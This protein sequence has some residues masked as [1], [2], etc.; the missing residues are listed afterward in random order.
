MHGPTQFSSIGMF[1]GASKR[2]KA[3]QQYQLQN[4]ERFS[5]LSISKRRKLFNTTSIRRRTF[6]TM[7]TP[8]RRSFSRSQASKRRKFL[9]SINTK[10]TKSFQLHQYQNDESF[11]T[12]SI[13]KRRE[14]IIITITKTTAASKIT[15]ITATKLQCQTQRRLLRFTDNH[16]KVLKCSD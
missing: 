8:E 7:P 14:L 6:S 2:R 9:S 5:S 11:S 1:L 16:Y 4:D 13:P 3:F 12:P 15:N 10:T